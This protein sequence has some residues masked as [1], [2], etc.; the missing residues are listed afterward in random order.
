MRN[1]HYSISRHD[2]IMM[3]GWHHWCPIYC[4]N[5]PTIITSAVNKHQN[6]NST[7]RNKTRSDARVEEKRTNERSKKSHHKSH[8][9]YCHPNGINFDSND[10]SASVHQ[11]SVVGSRQR[12]GVLFHSLTLGWR[13][14]KSNGKIASAEMREANNANEEKW[15][16]E[17]Q[18]PPR[19]GVQCTQ[20]RLI[21]A[22]DDMKIAWSKEIQY[23]FLF[24]IWQQCNDR[25]RHASH[26]FTSPVFFS[27]KMVL[28]I[29]YVLMTLLHVIMQLPTHAVAESRPIYMSLWLM[30]TRDSR[31]TFNTAPIGGSREVAE[32]YNLLQLICTF[33]ENKVPLSLHPFHMPKCLNS[34]W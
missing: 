1:I 19:R 6:I 8:G 23:C 13:E 9:I 20:S 24:S 14:H 16:Y 15:I 7:Q 28:N 26:F 27:R 2:T 3:I 21:A 25:L 17:L 18:V 5:S 29:I 30:W 10:M 31:T 11:L 34:Q 33:E 12:T 32:Q 4:A 22:I